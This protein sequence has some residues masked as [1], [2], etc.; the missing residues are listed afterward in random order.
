MA[1]PGYIFTG[2][3]VLHGEGSLVDEFPGRGCYDVSTEDPVC[4][5]VTYHLHQAIRIG[6][7][8]KKHQTEIVKGRVE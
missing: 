3:T 5:L 2:R 1:D 6:Y 7:K 8:K 4:L